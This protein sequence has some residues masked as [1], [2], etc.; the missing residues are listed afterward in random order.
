MVDAD[1]QS[2][3][4]WFY[5]WYLFTVTLHW[6]DAKNK[7]FDQLVCGYRGS[8]PRPRAQFAGNRQL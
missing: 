5:K 2:Y 3:P 4:L 7:V 8:S 6:N 1:R